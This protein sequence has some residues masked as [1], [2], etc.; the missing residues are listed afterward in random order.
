MAGLLALAGGAS[1]YWLWHSV[2]PDGA[3]SSKCNTESNGLLL[4]VFLALVGIGTTGLIA[5][6]FWLLNRR[7]NRQYPLWRPLRQAAWA[8]FFVMVA[9]WLQSSRAFSL[10]SALL[11]AGG[12]AL[13]EVFFILRQAPE[14]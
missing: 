3:L 8:G 4:A 10:I 12:L 2:C 14:H 11:L 9:G 5:P 13:L 7:L 6:L 1:A